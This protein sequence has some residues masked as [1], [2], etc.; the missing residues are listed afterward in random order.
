MKIEM[1][2]QKKVKLW[3]FSEA[4]FDWLDMGL[5]FESYCF[6]VTLFYTNLF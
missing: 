1:E 2:N 6:R 4:H 5:V 3:S